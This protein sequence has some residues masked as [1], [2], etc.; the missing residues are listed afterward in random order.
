MLD[1]LR[2]LQGVGGRQVAAKAVS[3]EHK[4][5]QAFGLAPIVQK[6]HKLAFQVAWLA[7]VKGR[8]RRGGETRQIN[9]VHMIARSQC[10]D[11]FDVGRGAGAQAV[12]EQQRRIVRGAELQRVQ[13]VAVSDWYIVDF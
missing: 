4:V 11:I 6:I 10:R 13:K 2:M 1:S 5:A 7:G 8:P 3:Q 9:G 12:D